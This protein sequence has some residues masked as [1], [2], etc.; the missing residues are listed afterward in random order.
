VV[1]SEIVLEVMKQTGWTIEYIENMIEKEMLKL[2]KQDGRNI[3]YIKNPSEEAMLE[4]WKSDDVNNFLK[5]IGYTGKPIEK[6]V[7]EDEK[8]ILNSRHSM[9]I[10]HSKGM[11]EIEKPRGIY[12]SKILSDEEIILEAEIRKNKFK[13]DY[14]QY[15]DRLVEQ[16]RSLEPLTK[17][18]WEK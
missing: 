8:S 16:T 5:A 13:L 2:V 9:S 18:N 14:G 11:N 6:D 3:K 1:Y 15:V 12:D 17:N 4:A 7:L 10:E